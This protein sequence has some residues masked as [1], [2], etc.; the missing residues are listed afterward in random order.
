[1]SASA[2]IQNPEST[3][4]SR[5]Q[6]A[7]AVSSRSPVRR[8]A[9]EAALALAVT[10]SF[11]AT[12]PSRAATDRTV[13]LDF[14]GEF[15]GAPFDCG[16]TVEGLGASDTDVTVSDYR[17]FVSEVRLIDAAGEETPLAL[18]A[19]GRWQGEG[20]ALLDFEDGSGNCTNGTPET[21]ASVVG[22]VPE[23]D[24]VGVAFEIGV[25]FD[26]NH[27]DP[28]LAGS[29]LNLTAMFWNWRGGYRFV[30]ID[31]AP[32]NEGEMSDQMPDD[33]STAAEHAG[34]PGESRAN[35]GHDGQTG[36]GTGSHAAMTESGDAGHGG[37]HGGAHGGRG[38]ALHLGSTRCDAPSPTTA[39]ESCA[40]P[41][42]VAVRFDDFDP[43]ADTIVVD[44]AAVLVEADLSSNAPDT[45]PG[46]MSAPDD[47]D[48]ESVMPRLGLGAE[49]GIEQT[50][51]SVR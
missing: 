30:R 13:T 27:G 20:V 26:V 5:F 44:P 51:M 14:A 21:N 48:C 33:Q 29:P 2:A 38:W 12:A 40:D 28:T 47:A 35:G 11:T 41:N 3:A 23:G 45:S 32:A 24:Y 6:T 37:M 25:P 43:D 19:D 17:L 39:P 15:A 36:D 18:E 49:G 7:N 42:R 8:A 9:R 22:T 34:G 10:A 50:L 16:R 4:V 46:C 1:M 31:M